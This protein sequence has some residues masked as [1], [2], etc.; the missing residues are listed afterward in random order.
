MYRQIIMNSEDANFQR[1]IWRNSSD[2]PYDHY[3]LTTVAYGTASAPFLA[4]KTLQ[5]LGQQNEEEFPEAAHIIQNHFYVDDLMSGGDDLNESLKLQQQIIQILQSGGL[6]L[7]K[8]ASNHKDLLS[9]IPMH[10]QELNSVNLPEESQ[11]IKTLGLNW[12]P[13]NDFFLFSG[14]FTTC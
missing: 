10:Q 9:N 5:K 2:Q 7:R 13:I 6:E 12:N 11:A 14:S 3:R 1:I 4:T 8:W